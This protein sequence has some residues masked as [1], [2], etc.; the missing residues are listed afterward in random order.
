MPSTAG[1]ELIESL[2]WERNPVGDGLQKWGGLLVASEAAGSYLLH[3]L[4]GK[5]VRKQA[6]VIGGWIYFYICVVK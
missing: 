5:E 2:G 1:E 3:N 4:R 6:G